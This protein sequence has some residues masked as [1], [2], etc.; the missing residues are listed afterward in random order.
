MAWIEDDQGAVLF[1]QQTAG[2]R[3]WTLPGGKV[4]AREAMRD[5]LIREVREET[6]LKVESLEM[7]HLMD[8]PERGAVMVLYRATAR[9]NKAPKLPK[10]EIAA[11][12]Y[13]TKLPKKVTPSAGFFWKL[14]REVAPSETP[15]EAG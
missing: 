10:S 5:A 12:R 13:V 3:F 7:L 2:Q 6:S 9:A 15:L 14:M 8:R 4:K 1:V 11:I